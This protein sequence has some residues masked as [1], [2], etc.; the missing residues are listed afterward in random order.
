MRKIRVQIPLTPT[1]AKTFFILYDFFSPMSNSGRAKRGQFRLTW[2]QI[3]VSSCL[4]F[5]FTYPQTIHLW[6]ICDV[7]TKLCTYWVFVRYEGPP[8][9]WNCNIWGLFCCSCLPWTRL[10]WAGLEGKSSM[11]PPSVTLWIVN[12]LW[13]I[14]THAICIVYFHSKP[15]LVYSS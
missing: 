11:I 8:I 3:D 9:F 15:A 6:T 4:F 1:L 12:K 2:V 13:E 14:F 5:V 7:R 10:T